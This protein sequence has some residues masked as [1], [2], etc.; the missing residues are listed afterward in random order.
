M[1]RV[2]IGYI[3]CDKK[4]GDDERFFLNIAKKKNIK[5]IILPFSD[6][7]DQ[8]RLEKI[9]KECDIVYN[10][11]AKDFSI[12]FAKTIETLGKKVIDSSKAYYFIE[13]K[14]IFFLKCKS[15]KISVPETI[16][17]SENKNIAR[18]ELK[19]FDHWPVILKR[20]EGCQ[21][22]FVGK[23]EN[24][25]KAFQLIKKFNKKGEG[26]LPII[27]QE[28]IPSISYRVTVIDDKIVQT[29]KKKH[30]G[31]KSTGAWASRHKRFKVD[32]ELR[33]I[34]KKIIKFSGIKILG[35]DLLK[36]ENKWVVLEINS[37]PTFGF[38]SVDRKK[39]IEKTLNFLKREALKSK[40]KS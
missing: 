39:L 21:G 25:N 2:V 1:K 10:A 23:V 26:K 20:I 29:V 5:L 38:I 16:L 8:E 7:K 9:V 33:K 3:S 36:K 6:I 11:S 31:W 22:E 32:D 28:F 13:D 19:K 40:N 14:W 4:I 27:A 24:L 18:S 12:E 30:Q 15:H 35:I 34:I 17:L 37:E